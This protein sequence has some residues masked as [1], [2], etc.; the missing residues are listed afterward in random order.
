MRR[1]QDDEK[2]ERRLRIEAF[3]KENLEA[4]WTA[5]GLSITGTTQKGREVMAAYAD[6]KGR[7][8]HDVK[9]SDIW[10]WSEMLFEEKQREQAGRA[11]T[12]AR[13]R[14]GSPQGHRSRSPQRRK[15]CSPQRHRSRSRSR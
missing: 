10:T 11:E 14:P 8:V 7:V 1:P 15:S 13:S 4:K 5:G 9:G 6:P 3:L 12:G 2:E